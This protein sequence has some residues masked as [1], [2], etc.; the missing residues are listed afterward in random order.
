MF[1]YVIQ[2]SWL[3]TRERSPCAQCL[4]GLLNLM[5]KPLLT[6]LP[7]ALSRQHYPSLLSRCPPGP[8]P[9]NEYITV[10]TPACPTQ[11]TRDTHP[12]LDTV[13]DEDPAPIAFSRPLRCPSQL[14]PCPTTPTTCTLPTPLLPCTCLPQHIFYSSIQPPVSTDNTLLHRVSNLRSGLFFW[15]S[16]LIQ[17]FMSYVVSSLWL[18]IWWRT[19]APAKSVL[20]RVLPLLFN[21]A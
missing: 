18:E 10:H 3:T 19:P 11:I 7:S 2:H 9:S 6:T 1:S 17:A 14:Q 12:T 13:A 20:Q 4:V 8:S 5:S 15:F 21:S 16:C